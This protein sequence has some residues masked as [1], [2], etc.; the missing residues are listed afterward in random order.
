MR[1]AKSKFP[2][3]YEILLK[4]ICSCCKNSCKIRFNRGERYIFRWNLGPRWSGAISA[5]F[6]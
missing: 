4:E 1:F 5:S 3:A 2:T 6:A